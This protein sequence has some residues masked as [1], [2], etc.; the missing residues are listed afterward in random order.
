MGEP[1][2]V[3]QTVVTDVPVGDGVVIPEQHAVDGACGGNLLFRENLLQGGL[4][5]RVVEF[6]VQAQ[7]ELLLHWAFDLV[8][9][10]SLLQLCF[11]L[12]RLRELTPTKGGL[13]E[14]HDE[15]VP[16]SHRPLSPANRS[17]V[18]WGEWVGK[19]YRQRCDEDLDVNIDAIARSKERL[20]ALLRHRCRAHKT[21]P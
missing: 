18:C 15:E 4:P 19:R 2:A 6:V 16:P 17:T 1:I 10:A 12:G 20:A 14:D 3:C 7:E 8:Q 11:Q 9:F 5:E 13:L 21:A